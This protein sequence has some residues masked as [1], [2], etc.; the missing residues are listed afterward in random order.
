MMKIISELVTRAV[1][2]VHKSSDSDSDSD[3]SIVRTS[4]SDYSIFK[5]PTQTPS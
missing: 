2:S 5:T 1:E 3:C 4:D